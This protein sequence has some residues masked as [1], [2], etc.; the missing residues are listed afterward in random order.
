MN[1]LV[2]ED[3]PVICEVLRLALE[4]QGH[5]VTLAG[6]AA[7]ALA[8]MDEAPPHLVILDITLPGRLDGYDICRHIRG[9][10]RLKRAVVYMLSAR[11]VLEDQVEAR[12]AGANRYFVKPFSALALLAAV[13]QEAR[14]HG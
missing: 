3:H 1:I 12:R 2:V 5:R 13:D 6:D 4:P 14:H 10:E 9:H 7:T 8:R 11:A